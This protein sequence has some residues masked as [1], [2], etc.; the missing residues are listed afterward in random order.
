MHAA[1]RKTCV[2]LLC[3]STARLPA[4]RTQWG[5]LHSCIA[6]HSSNSMTEEGSGQY[7]Y[8]WPRPAVTVDTVIVA[9]PQEGVSAK[10]LL[11]QRKH[12]PF[13]VRACALTCNHKQ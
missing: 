9:R 4:V 2:Q 7:T 6:A 8:R 11:I 10:V 5:R 1:V 13:Q 3:S 12:P